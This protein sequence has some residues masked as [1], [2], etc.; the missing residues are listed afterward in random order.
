[1]IPSRHFHTSDLLAEDVP[2]GH[3]QTLNRLLINNILLIFQ[4]DLAG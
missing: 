2:L 4:S 1:M 3:S